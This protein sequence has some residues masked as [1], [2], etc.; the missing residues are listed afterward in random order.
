[1]IRKISAILITVVLL[2]SVCIIPAYAI[3]YGCD[4]DTSTPCIYLK[5]L[6]TGE[7]IL[8]KEAD[9]VVYPASLTKIMTYLVVT[10]NVDDYDNTTVT[11]EDSMFNSLDP[12]SSVMGLQQHE[13]ESFSIRDLLYGMMVASGNDA[14]WVLAGYVGG[15]VDQFV[16]MMNDK[17][18]SLGLSNTHFVNPHG[19]HD[20]NHYTTAK[21]LCVIT[22]EAMKD[23]DFMT[24][25]N[26]TLYKPKGFDNEVKTTNYLIDKNQEDGKYFYDFARG[27]KTGYTS[28]AGKC[29]VS[30]ADNGEYQYLMIE[31]GSPYS[32]EENVNYAMIDAKNIYSWCFDNLGFVTLKEQAEVVDTLPVKFVWG[33][34]TTDVI[35]DDGISAFLPKNYSEEDVKM[36]L[37]LDEYI[38]APIKKGEEVGTCTVY[39]KGEE[40]GTSKIV[41]SEDI[42]SNITNVIYTKVR[43]FAV[44]NTL[45]TG[46]IVAIIILIIVLIIVITN[47]VKR[48]KRQKAYDYDYRYDDYDRVERRT[49]QKR[50]SGK[51]SSRHYKSRH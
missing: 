3:D 31:L 32:Y 42:N 41:A 48:S 7:V 29:L 19:L 25:C 4:V 44:N 30:S 17:A 14:A 33:D 12:E 45:L 18:S 26:M 2:I 13:G 6:N 15:T 10:E 16:T 36:E 40:I 46:I 34:K 24:I 23:P 49:P 11:I 9:K 38:E 50:Y 21:D 47:N 5:N 43:D 28:E 1:M 22:E 51:K 39:F 20:D 37:N 27:I 8:E 35:A